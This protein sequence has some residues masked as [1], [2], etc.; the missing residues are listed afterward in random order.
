V[1]E[2]SHGKQKFQPKEKDTDVQDKFIIISERDNEAE[3]FTV[4]TTT[5]TYLC[6]VFGYNSLFY[7]I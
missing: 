4:N 6:S 5:T 1:N 7:H 3:F 2:A